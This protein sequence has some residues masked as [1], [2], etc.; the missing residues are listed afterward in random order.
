MSI[1][2][3]IGIPINEVNRYSDLISRENIGMTI[4]QRIKAARQEIPLTQTE[5]G[6]KVGLRQS[7]ISELEKGDSA[8]TAYL[9]SIAS[10]LG[11]S[12]LW[13]ETGKGPKYPIKSITP[14]EMLLIAAY[15][16]ATEEGK[17]F[18]EMACDSAPKVTRE[19]AE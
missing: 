5:L 17:T 16:D 18:I 14:K 2:T 12:A 10:V 9:A 8:G 1:R 11:L 19:K 6:T 13:L 4:G 3:I 7:T 15:R